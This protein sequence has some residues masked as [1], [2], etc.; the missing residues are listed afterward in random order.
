M[1][2]RYVVAVLA[3]LTV[4]LTSEASK[5]VNLSPYPYEKEVRETDLPC[6]DKD[7]IMPCTCHTD[8]L[9]LMTMDCSLIHSNDELQRIF[10]FEFPFKHFYKLII[11]HDPNDA[12][13]I[14]TEIHSDTFK[15]LT[16]QRVVIRGT[17]L[18]TIDENVFH[19]SHD[20]LNLFDL[21]NNKLSKFPFETLFLYSRLETL[22]LDNNNFGALEKFGS[23]SL[24]I[25]SIGYNSNL[26]F[27]ND[28]LEE[29]PC[30]VTL[31]MDSIGLKYI[32]QHMFANLTQV[33]SISFNNNDLTVLREFSIN[34]LLPTVGRLVL[35][36]NRLSDFDQNSIT[37]LKDNAIVDLTNNRITEMP[38]ELCKPFFEQVINGMVDLT[39][40]DLTCGCDMSWLYLNTTTVDPTQRYLPIITKHTTCFDGTQV[41]YLDVH[42]FEKH[43]NEMSRHISL[44]DLENY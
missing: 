23:T 41:I 9:G 14:L 42:V 20:T 5:C 16:F 28:V 2:L 26:K 10:S 30:I 37:G 1:A 15:K 25:L 19:D 11:D 35:G 39:G 44:L 31:N 29:L 33:Y 34:P 38:E 24:R 7:Q 18:Q 21:R 4:A 43:C 3:A 36:N 8:T 27:T 13:N 17:Q 12:E 32:P 40:N 6:P 22:L